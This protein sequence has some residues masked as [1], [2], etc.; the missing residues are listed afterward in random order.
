MPSSAFSAIVL[1]CFVTS[2]AVAMNRATDRSPVSES[3]VTAA[4]CSERARNVAFVMRIVRNE[5]AAGADEII[6]QFERIGLPNASLARETHLKVVR[7]PEQFAI[8]DGEYL[9]T[10]L[11]MQDV[12]Q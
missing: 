1:L 5:N 12:M 9:A 11:C 4:V 3:D 7:N 8:E 6:G 2:A 10:V